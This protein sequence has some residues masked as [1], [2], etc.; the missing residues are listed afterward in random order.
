MYLL[1][2]VQCTQLYMYMCMYRAC[3]PV[4]AIYSYST[5]VE[6]LYKIIILV[7]PLHSYVYVICHEVYACN[8]KILVQTQTKSK[9]VVC[10]FFFPSSVYD[11]LCSTRR[12]NHTRTYML[13]ISVYNTLFHNFHLML[14]LFFFFAFYFPSPAFCLV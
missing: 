13:C 2:L 1:Y 4:L 9:T 5:L 11:K 7:M 8:W 12:D 14:P 6:Q 10:F 3:F